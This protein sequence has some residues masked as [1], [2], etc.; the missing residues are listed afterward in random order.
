MMITL[1]MCFAAPR[2][3]RSTCARAR[4]AVD[5]RVGVQTCGHPDGRQVALARLDVGCGVVERISRCTPLRVRERVRVPRGC[6]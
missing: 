4:D 2:A 3:S 5:K 1:S 6:A